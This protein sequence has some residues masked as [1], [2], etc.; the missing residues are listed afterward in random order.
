MIKNF[1]Q[2]HNGKE[3]PYLTK[4]IY[5]KIQNILIGEIL[6]VPHQDWEE[7]GYV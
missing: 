2:K 1:Q 4:G 6:N 7:G 3:L 5:K